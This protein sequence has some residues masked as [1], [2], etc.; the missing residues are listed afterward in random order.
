MRWS[1]KNISH[2][3]SF[4]A[5]FGKCVNPMSH[6]QAYTWANI[7]KASTMPCISGRWPRSRTGVRP[8]PR[9]WVGPCSGTSWRWI[10]TASFS[11]SRVSYQRSKFVL[12]SSKFERRFWLWIQNR[13][14]NRHYSW[15]IR[16]CRVKA[17]LSEYT[18][19]WIFSDQIWGKN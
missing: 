10:R 17:A 19:I 8:R 9:P 5:L 4:W 7:H 14:E 6:E 18:L 1:N 2:I 13:R 11:F 16:Y 12:L 3:T 15:T